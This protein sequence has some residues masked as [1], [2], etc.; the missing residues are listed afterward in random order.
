[1]HDFLHRL[2]C[3]CSKR[4]YVLYKCGTWKVDFCDVENVLDLATR[5]PPLY[6]ALSETF[7]SIPA[8]WVRGFA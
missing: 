3:T 5:A 4:T 6:Q 1:M 7:V 2:L 8:I